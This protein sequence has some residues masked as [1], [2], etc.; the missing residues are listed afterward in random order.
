ML[1][2]TDS[3]TKTCGVYGYC[4]SEFEKEKSNHYCS[5]DC[6]NYSDMPGR[7]SSNS[8]WFHRWPSEGSCIYNVFGNA[9]P[10]TR[11]K[12]SLSNRQSKTS[13]IN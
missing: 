6:V 5:L 12:N 7:S 1:W 4:A 8:I 13:E 10:E 2:P 11:L 9:L 3:R